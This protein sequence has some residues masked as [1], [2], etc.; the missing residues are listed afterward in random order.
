MPPMGSL[1][2]FP[3]GS[4]TVSL[5][6]HPQVPGLFQFADFVSEF[7]ENALLDALDHP[8][9]GHTG[10]VPMGMGHGQSGMVF[11]GRILPFMA[12]HSNYFY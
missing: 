6:S 2:I 5:R 4:S 8:A 9:P 10:F 1:L 3:P 11:K 12:P 7:E